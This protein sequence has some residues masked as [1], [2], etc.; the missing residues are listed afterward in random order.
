MNKFILFAVTNLLVLSPFNNI[1]LNIF[2]EGNL[3][4]VVVAQSNR[5]LIYDPPSNVRKTPNGQIICSIKTPTTIE[6]Y[7][8][9]DGWYK[10][11]V[12]GSNGYI[13]KSQVRF[14]NRNQSQPTNNGDYY[15][16]NRT[17]FH[18]CD[19]PIL[20]TGSQC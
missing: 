10:T 14:Q 12:C 8:Y 4:S 2:S 13:H 20:V 18:P 5:L 3:S 6:A 1:G 11:N 17:E 9:T 7:G 16:P 19:N 15:N